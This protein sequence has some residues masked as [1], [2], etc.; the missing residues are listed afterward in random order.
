MLAHLVELVS[1]CVA[2]DDDLVDLIVLKLLS[3][4][5]EKNFMRLVSKSAFGLDGS[6]ECLEIGWIFGEV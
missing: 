5:I 6:H 2:D 3:D 4:I 1:R